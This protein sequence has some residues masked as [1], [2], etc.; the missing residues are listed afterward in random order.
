MDNPGSIDRRSGLSPTYG[1][2]TI[3]VDF[4]KS[5]RGSGNKKATC[6]FVRMLAWFLSNMH[7]VNIKTGS[8]DRKAQNNSG[9]VVPAQAGTQ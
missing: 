2:L 3:R 9:F 1:L 6:F 8:F 7:N 5:Q 4:N